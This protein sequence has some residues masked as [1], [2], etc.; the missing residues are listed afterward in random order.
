MRTDPPAALRCAISAS[1][2]SGAPPLTVNFT[3][4]V[5]G[6]SGSET[7]QWQFGDAG[8]NGSSSPNA[9]FT[10]TTTGAYWARLRVTDSSG[11]RA[12]AHTLIQVSSGSSCSVSCS[13]TVPTASTPGST[14]YFQSTASASGCSG[15][16][17]YR[18]TFGDGQSSTQQNVSHAYASPGSYNWTLTVTAGTGTCTRSGTITI[19]APQTSTNKRRS[20]VPPGGGGTG[21]GSVSVSISGTTATVTQSGN[22]SGLAWSF[23]QSVPSGFSV[24]TLP[25]A[26]APAIPSGV[27]RLS[28]F[29]TVSPSVAGSDLIAVTLP[30]S[31]L[32]S[33]RSA[34]DL[35]LYVHTD[36][37]VDEEDGG[38]SFKGKFWIRSWYD[39][40]VLS[41]GKTQIKLT[42]L[43]DLSF[44]GIEAPVSPPPAESFMRMTIGPTAV[45]SSCAAKALAN[46]TTDA[47]QQV[48]TIGYETGKSFVATVKNLGDLHLTPAATLA[49]LTGWLGA[50]RAAFDGYGMSSD[51]TFEVDIG[52]MPADA[53]KALGFVTRRNHEDYRV[54][55]ITNAPKARNSIQGT[56][57]HEY[58]HH[59]QARTT[60]GGKSNLLGGGAATLWLTEGLAR[61]VEDDIFDALNTYTLK[62]A[63]PLARLMAVGLA[64]SD[65]SAN[66]GRT[67][68]YA[69]FAF[70]KMVQ[71][72]CSGFQIPQILNVI[73]AQDPSG[74]KNFKAKLESDSWQCDFGA[75]LGE[76]NRRTLAAALT[77]YMFA[78]VKNDD[79]SLLDSNEPSGYGFATTAGL[80]SVTPSADCKADSPCNSSRLVATLPPGAS[81]AVVLN[82]VSS[83]PDGMIPMVW[84]DVD[85]PGADAF[86][87]V[88]DAEKLLTSASQGG[89]TGGGGSVAYGEAGR[90]PQALAFLVNPSVT[91][92][93]A[94]KLRAGFATGL[95]FLSDQFTEPLFDWG[96]P[97]REYDFSVHL[98]GIDETKTRYVWSFG[99]GTAKTTVTGSNTVKHTYTSEG[100]FTL[101]VEL[102]DIASGAKL[103][104]GSTIAKIGWFRGT[105]AINTLS[106]I[107]TGSIT[108]PSVLADEKTLI[109]GITAN[110]ASG[111]I[112]FVELSGARSIWLSTAANH[113]AIGAPSSD[114]TWD[115]QS[116]MNFS[117]S[118]LTARGV[119]YGYTPLAGGTFA[120]L[121]FDGSYT[122]AGANLSGTF[123]LVGRSMT[124]PPVETGRTVYS[125]TA[126]RRE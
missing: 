100:Q 115:L 60:E 113:M 81:A 111:R 112:E 79:L 10:Y 91:S 73:Q 82:A 78:T 107:P 4:S 101:G 57:V 16:P 56:A 76:D 51:A 71:M 72:S 104:T 7:Y 95:T 25:A 26:Q 49:D 59:A 124:V 23:P 120:V 90:A 116:F 46:G 93:V 65:D 105:F 102:Y 21:S 62:E 19:T 54:L 103:V 30:V 42:G 13:A 52:P 84:L 92:P 63:N 118:S 32:P 67:R 24:S 66:D 89:G 80:P 98:A 33:G 96:R 37:A 44:V 28:D 64:A 11:A 22:L 110:P 86:V 8:S 41:S 18:W 87:W 109:D 40:N 114:A 94:I 39:L 70:W 17:D 99:D 14:P 31:A 126:T 48:C 122:Q 27:T 55:H 121:W 68:G 58:F 2:S 35:R 85:T 20:V 88:G 61:W 69:R 29:F 3:P 9:S 50:A 123:T 34:K 125:F 15:N 77:K 36:A 12:Y 45:T 1:P 47:N 97:Q 117:G 106:A 38:N 108:W 119:R 83:A 53:P 74:V 75:G 6:S 5:Y 43:G